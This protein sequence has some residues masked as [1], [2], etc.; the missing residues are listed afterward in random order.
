MDYKELRKLMVK[1]QLIPRG[2]KDKRVLDA[3]ER[4]PR[5]LFVDSSTYHQRL[6]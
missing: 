2:I 6:F 1:T 3:M 5:H 4:V